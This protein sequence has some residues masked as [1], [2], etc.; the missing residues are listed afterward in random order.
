MVSHCPK[1]AKEQN[2]FVLS[3]VPGGITNLQTLIYFLRTEVDKEE[4]SA[5][6]IEYYGKG[7][8]KKSVNEQMAS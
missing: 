8:I 5:E 1:R 4:N 6:I 7:R 2:T 3:S